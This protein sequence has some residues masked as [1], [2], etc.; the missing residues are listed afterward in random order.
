M[1]SLTSFKMIALVPLFSAVAMAKTVTEQKIDESLVAAK[2]AHLS[3]LPQFI[4]EHVAVCGLY[5]GETKS[6]CLEE[7]LK[8]AE[9][10]L[11]CPTSEK[12]FAE[13]IAYDEATSKDSFLKNPEAVIPPGIQKNFEKLVAVVKQQNGQP[14]DLKLKL[15]AYQSSNKNAH[16]AVGGSVF[17]SD[18]LWKGDNPMTDDEVTAVLAH[19]VTHVMHLHG[20]LLNCM[21]IE[22]TSTDFNVLE[23]QQAFQEDFQ[24]SQR[25]SIWSQLSV[26]LEYDADAGA[27]K[28]L[29]AAGFDPLL[30][31][32]ALEKLRPKNE[33]GFTSGSHPDFDVRIETVRAEAL[34][35]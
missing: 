30:M 16:A 25:F 20:M 23:A 29:K 33:G 24:G 6:H 7:T 13:G 18:G 11:S 8:Q 34:K 31:A 12:R 15:R 35:N 19:E 21:A 27:T 2:A 10:V 14:F 5:T 3:Y 1:K 4:E 17:A 28:I 22:W 9:G 32:Q 26:S